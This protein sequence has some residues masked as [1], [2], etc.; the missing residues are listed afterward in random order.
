M[1]NP[2]NQPAKRIVSIDILRGAVMIIM[3]LDH[4]RDFF[5]I[6]AF[7]DDPTN[8]ATTT[9]LLFFTRWI[10]HFCAPVFLFLSGTSAFLAGQKKTTKEHSIF[11]IKR[12]LW[13]VFVELIVIT[14]GWTFNPLYNVFILQVIWAIGC[15]MIILGLL[16]RTSL[17]VI[18]ITGLI[19]TAGHNIIDYIQP[20]QEGPAYVVYTIL[21]KGA[22]AFFPYTAQR[23]FLDVYAILPW[24]G[25]MLLGYAAGKYFLPQVTA[26]KRKQA[27]MTLGIATT[28]LFVVL[29]FINGYGDPK[30]WAAQT[31]VLY[32]IFSFVNTTKYPASLLYL[33]M[34]IGP[35]LIV[36]SLIG[37][38]QNRVS[39]ILITYGRVPFLYYVLH[40]YLIHLFCV[41]AF[42]ASGHGVHEIIDPNLPFLFRPVKYGFDLWVV[43]LVW[44]IVVVVLYWPCKW[45]NRYRAT[46]R[47]WWLSYI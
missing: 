19:I 43:Y 1:S 36:L 9:P 23:G 31:S 37:H 7:D 14:L 28:L 38:V 17:P 34:T 35:A 44:I 21:F 41:I 46:H 40:F 4:V 20:P 5:H 25:V 16:V 39:A 29:R 8:L 2:G 12:G 45:F 11:L 30:P 6:H 47:Q 13:L 26:G 15:S 3:A 32:T 33:C 42:F 10:T 27:L 24:T 22:F 18:F